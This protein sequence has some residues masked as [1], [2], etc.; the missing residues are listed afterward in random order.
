MKNELSPVVIKNSGNKNFFYKTRD[1]IFFLFTIYIWWVVLL[2]FYLELMGDSPQLDSLLSATILKIFLS[3]F[4]FSFLGFHCWAIYNL[5]LYHTVNR[6]NLQKTVSQ[7]P[8]IPFPLKDN[9]PLIS[10]LTDA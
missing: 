10:N 1:S 5:R 2:N 9:Y 3:G 4:I 8:T 6:R 7:D